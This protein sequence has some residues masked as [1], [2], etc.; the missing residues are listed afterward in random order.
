MLQARVRQTLKKMLLQ[1]QPV[2]T[3]RGSKLVSF[4]RFDWL[5]AEPE[6]TIEHAESVTPL[7][8]SAKGFYK[9]CYVRIFVTKTYFS[10]LEECGIVEL[11][12]V[13]VFVSSKQS[14]ELGEESGN[15]VVQ[16]LER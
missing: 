13:V 16:V 5:R 4:Q 7:K 15:E 6:E 11:D 10:D 9:N 12:D 3:K 14:L 2:Q 8:K 1:P